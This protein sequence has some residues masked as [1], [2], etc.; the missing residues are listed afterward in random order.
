MQAWLDTAAAI[1]E[2]AGDRIV[3]AWRG[4]RNVTHKGAVDLVTDTDTEVEELVVHRLREAFPSHEI[5]AEES[6][7]ADPRERIGAAAHAWIVDPVDGTTNFAHGYPHVAVS[8][9][10]MK[11]G[12]PALGVVRDPLRRETFTAV[13]GHGAFLDGSRIQVSTTAN[14]DA[15]LIGTGFPYDRREHAAA[16]LRFV[17]DFLERVQGI[18][19]AGTASLDLCWVA[20]GRLDGFWEL[21]L[22]PWDVAAG[23]AIVLEAGGWVTDFADGP[24]DACAGQLV[25]SNGSIHAAMCE[26][27]AARLEL[28]SSL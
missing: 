20:C 25:A 18:R 16:Y 10:L 5:V 8:I 21:K 23:A 4:R 14:L 26:L 19:R 2:E 11:H 27:T 3:R 6:A 24:F 17:Q 1:A 15:A 9:G 13:R 7:E 22:K 28:E 12:V